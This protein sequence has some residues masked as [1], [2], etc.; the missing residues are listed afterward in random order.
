[1]RL[2]GTTGQAESHTGGE[3]RKDSHYSSALL[4]MPIGVKYPLA[5]R[6]DEI[7]KIRNRL[8]NF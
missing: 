4:P 5:G 6:S 1:M 8:V 3:E 7:W 2:L